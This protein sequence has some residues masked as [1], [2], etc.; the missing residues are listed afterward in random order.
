MRSVHRHKAGGSNGLLLTKGIGLGWALLPGRFS[1]PVVTA[2]RADPGIS[3]QNK[4]EGMEYGY[5]ES[6]G[7]VENQTEASNWT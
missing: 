5:S 4:N 1:Y 7:E 2:S 3:K 6:D